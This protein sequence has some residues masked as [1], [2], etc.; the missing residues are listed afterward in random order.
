MA[1]RAEVNELAG[2]LVKESSPIGRGGGQKERGGIEVEEMAAVGDFIFGVAVGEEAKVADTDEACG[3][4]VEEEAPKELDGSEGECFFDSPVAVILPT[5]ADATV[6]D[7]QQAVVGD[8]SAMGV[9]SEIVEDLGG[10]AEGLLGVDDPAAVG[11]GAQPAAEGLRVGEAGE[12]AQ[13]GK[14]SLL[15]GL[16]QGGAEEVAEAGA[17]DLDGEEEVLAAVF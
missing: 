1:E 4:D 17:E 10:A 3:Q 8:G 9:A 2:E 15:E 12:I 5:E 11:G 13:E 14:L 7:L 16:Q 6:F